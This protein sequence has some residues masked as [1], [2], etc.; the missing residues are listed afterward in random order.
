M[1]CASAGT[2]A[3]RPPTGTAGRCD[4]PPGRQ[5][6]NA[7]PTVSRAGRTRILR[8]HSIRGLTMG[9]TTNHT[10][11]AAPVPL[12]TP[13]PVEEALRSRRRVRAFPTAPVPRSTVERLLALGAED[14]RPATLRRAGGVQRS[15]RIV[16]KGRCPMRVRARSPILKW[17]DP[18]GSRPDRCGAEVRVIGTVD[19]GRTVHS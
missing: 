12:P 17:L 3:R 14:G 4:E 9:M 15:N 19:N 8:D 13:A 2:C 18:S 10:S 1:R 7:A 16:G 6:R 11:A 5:I